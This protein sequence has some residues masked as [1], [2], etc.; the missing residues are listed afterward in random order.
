MYT[1]SQGKGIPGGLI[2]PFA[3]VAFEMR[4]AETHHAANPGT[5]GYARVYECTVAVFTFSKVL[6]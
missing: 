5:D 3:F 1:Q 6:Y 4:K 2:G